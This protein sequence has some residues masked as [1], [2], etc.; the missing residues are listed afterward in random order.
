MELG[1]DSIN[2]Q[3][4]LKTG[5]DIDQVSFRQRETHLECCNLGRGHVYELSME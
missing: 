2:C 5:K 4:G 3:L 1:V